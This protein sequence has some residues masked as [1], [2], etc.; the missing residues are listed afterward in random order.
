MSASAPADLPPPDLTPP[1]DP[2]PAPAPAP[3]ID[4]GQL[5]Q[6]NAQALAPVLQQ[7][8]PRPPAPAHEAPD[9]FAIPPG[10]DGAAAAKWVQDRVQTL[11]DARAEA[12]VNAAM[13][14]FE[15]RM[16]AALRGRDEYFAMQFAADP[17]FAALKAHLDR[18][19]QAGFNAKD[20]R[21]LAERDAGM[22]TS[23]SAPGAPAT[24]VVGTPP[25]HLTTPTGRAGS[26][27]PVNGFDAEKFKNDENYRFVRF[28]QHAAANGLT[29]D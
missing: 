29:L 15:A 3:S 24:R 6:A 4:Y 23:A 1:A 13:K 14:D 26:N 7:F 17:K 18:Y 2:A 11:A 8:A 9:Y 10:L 20:A 21:Y 16:G 12:K 5:A 27:A 22:H 19:A 28:K 25:P